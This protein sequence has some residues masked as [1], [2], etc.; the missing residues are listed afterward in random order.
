M[1]GVEGTPSE[2]AVD[3]ERLFEKVSR[4]HVGGSSSLTYYEVEE[5]RYA[6]LKESAKG[7][8]HGDIF[9]IPAVRS[10]SFQVQTVI[11]IFKLSVCPLTHATIRRQLQQP[12]LQ[13]RGI[14]SADALHAASAIE[15]DADILVSTDQALLQLDGILVNIRGVRILCC[16]TDSALQFL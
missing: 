1:P 15:F 5:A 11:H 4:A 2:L 6:S 3:A 14:R 16:D 10:I 8:S 9:L 12:D 7:I 13:T